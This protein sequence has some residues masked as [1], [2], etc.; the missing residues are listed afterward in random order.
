MAKE[1]LHSKKCGFF[2]LVPNKYYY[3]VSMK[4]A[5]LLTSLACIALAVSVQAGGNVE[6]KEIP[7]PKIEK[8]N[9]VPVLDLSQLDFHTSEFDIAAIDYVNPIS[10]EARIYH[11]TTALPVR[12]GFEREMLQPPLHGSNADTNL[13]Y[14]PGS[15]LQ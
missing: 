11:A 5:I 15:R 13:W 3:L 4:K 7:V 14:D 12:E 6:V 1:R 8:K 9:V 10:E 2:F